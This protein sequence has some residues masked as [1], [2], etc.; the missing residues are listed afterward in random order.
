MLLLEI[1]F[2]KRVM[3]LPILPENTSKF[4][5]V[6]KPLGHPSTGQGVTLNVLGW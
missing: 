1:D 5:P 4:M 3:V 6:W 2:T